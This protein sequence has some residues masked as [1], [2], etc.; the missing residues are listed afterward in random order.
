MAC[1]LFDLKTLSER[2]YILCTNF[3][4]KLFT[5]DKSEQ[6]FKQRKV[7]TRNDD[8][9]IEKKCNTKRC[10]NAPHNYVARLVNQNK[11]KLKN[12]Q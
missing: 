10:F 2:R 3:A 7:K 11:H 6:F 9:L 8:L 12:K 1:K 5:S 4:L